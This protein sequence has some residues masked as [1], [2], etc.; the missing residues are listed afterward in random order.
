MK[1]GIFLPARLLAPTLQVWRRLM[2][3]GQ[4]EAA[5]YPVKDEIEALALKENARP[6]GTTKGA[7]GAE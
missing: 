3:A 1:R 6:N 2:S 7:Q 4:L 5:F